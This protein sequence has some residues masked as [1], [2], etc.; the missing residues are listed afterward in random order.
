MKKLVR[1]KTNR[2]VSG[3]CAGIADYANV[4]VTV[5]R[6]VALAMIVLSGV[7]PGIFLYLIAVLITP[8]EGA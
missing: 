3:L 5:V 2:K 7:L 8:L 1:S 6:L 4:D